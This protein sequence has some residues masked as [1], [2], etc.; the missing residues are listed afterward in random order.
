MQGQGE[1]QSVI[2]LVAA[3]G[4]FNDYFDYQH[5]NTNPGAAFS[6]GLFFS[7]NDMAT[8]GFTFFTPQAA[9]QQSGT[10]P[11]DI[12]GSGT[13]YVSL[14]AGAGNNLYALE[15]TSPTVDVFDTTPAKVVA[16]GSAVFRRKNPASRFP[17]GPERRPSPMTRTTALCGLCHPARC[18]AIA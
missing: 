15:Q 14:A 17:A 8:T 3:N 7:A 13:A 2:S 16:N 9:T 18:S 1:E 4:H 6:N 5:Y 11:Y 10:G 12:V